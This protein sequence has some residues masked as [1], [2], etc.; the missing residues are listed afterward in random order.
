[1]ANDKLVNPG[2]VELSEQELAAI[3]GGTLT[4]ISD[5]KESIS[6]TLD[7]ALKLSPIAEIKFPEMGDLCSPPPKSDCGCSDVISI[8]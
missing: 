2:A 8:S 3:A 7:E 1:M 4:S 5:L 6:K